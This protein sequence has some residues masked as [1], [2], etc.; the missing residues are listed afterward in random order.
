MLRISNGII[1]DPANGIRG[2]VGDIFIEGQ[3]IVPPP[4]PGTPCEVLDATGLIVAPGAIDIHTHVAGPKVTAGR[5]LRPEDHY[6]DP[7]K[8]IRAFRSG[9]GHTVPSIF[10]TGYRYC[11]MGYTTVF[12]ASTPPLKARHVHE[13]LADLP[14]VDKGCYILMGNNYFVMKAIKTRDRNLLKEFVGWLLRAAGGYAIKIVNPGGVENWKWGQGSV[15]LD[16]PVP[17]FGVTPRDI[18][19]ALSEVSED[20]GLPHP[21]HVH[22]ND[23][24]RPGNVRTTLE[25]MRTLAGRRVHFTHL[26]FHSYD[27]TQKGGFRSGAAQVVEF[28]R[29][30][31]EFTADVGQV[32]FGP[33]TTMTADSPL[34]YSLHR[35]TGGKWGS[36][37]LEME[38]GSGVVPIVYRRNALVNAVQWAIGL[39]LLLLTEN[40]WQMFLTTDHP[41]GAPFS[42]YPE[43]IKLLMDPDYRRSELDRL[44]PRVRQLTQLAQLD[45]AYTLEEILVITRA[46]PARALGLRHKGHLG[47]GA[48]ADV[49]IYRKQEDAAAMFSR[50]A[51]VFK[52]GRLVAKEGELVA[53]AEGKTLV[54]DFEG[55]YELPSVFREEFARYYSV[56]L[57]NYPVEEDYLRRREVVVCS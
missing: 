1:F 13:E 31:P 46:G 45:R 29:E 55:N 20:L 14:L 56:S 19:L 33:A 21:V 25:S 36:C 26:Q 43:I 44:P 35:L 16:T 54:V 6:P 34:E 2:Q 48:D 4:P 32:M 40:P 9:T 28:L 11:A 3:K 15:T 47:V 51:Y 39:E 10:V 42:A 50:P 12:E 24:G 53:D 8:R 37:D 17:P 52:G 18:L 5:V 22:C 30:H 49:A 41:N 27:L 57:A 7:V 23:I 38:T